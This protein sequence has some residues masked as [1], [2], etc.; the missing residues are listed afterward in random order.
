MQCEWDSFLK[1]LPRRMRQAVD[2]QGRDTLQE[3]RLRL[4][5]PPELVT[6]RGSFWLE[7]A[8][9]REELAFCLMAASRYS[10][11]T[12]ESAAKGFITA[13]GGHRVG[14]CGAGIRREGGS[15]TREVT[16]LCLRV[17]RDFPGIAAGLPKEGSLLILGAP[18]WGK[19]TL[20][21]DLIRQRS[22]HE[23]VAVVD[24][25]GELFP[26][27]FGRGVRVDVLTGIG[28]AEGIDRVLRTMGPGCI[29]VDEI[30]AG[31]D[32]DAFARAAGCG[33]NLLATAHAGSMEQFRSRNAYREIWNRGIFDRC[34]VLKGD[35]TF[36]VEERS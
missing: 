2:G 5:S 26:E 9:T 7:G 3:L 15:L 11:W 31:E 21:R 20:L 22:Q 29:A 24:E 4:S 17:A 34:V 33:A 16:S 30:T 28:K 1:L 23:A 18:G 32:A 10:P 25:R 35:R 12:A 19:T 8:V 13:P 36:T 27:G 14:L 6:V